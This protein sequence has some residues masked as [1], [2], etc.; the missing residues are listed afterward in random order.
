MV[1]DVTIFNTAW[2][3]EK[4]LSDYYGKM[5]LLTEGQASEALKMLS[6]WEKAHEK[7]F[8]EY[9]DKLSAV[10]AEMPWGG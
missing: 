8:R 2:L 3:I 5:A 1:P 7:F 4:D 10:Y 6:E 9:R